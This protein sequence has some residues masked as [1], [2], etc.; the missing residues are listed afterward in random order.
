MHDN[1]VISKIKVF[2]L[3]LSNFNQNSIKFNIEINLNNG[4][5]SSVSNLFLNIATFQKI[6]PGRAEVM[7]IYF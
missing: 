3:K 6:G 4:L 2:A 1:K 7:I 5:Y